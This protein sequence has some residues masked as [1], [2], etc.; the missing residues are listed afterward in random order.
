MRR[1]LTLSACEIARELA[2]KPRPALRAAPDHDGVGAGSEQRDV[3]IVEWLNVAIDDDRDRDRLLDGAHRR[4]VG[5]AVVELAAGT[6]VHGDK[7][8]AR[9]FGAARQIGRVERGVVPAKPHFQR[10]RNLDRRHDC[11]DQGERMVEIAHQRRTG[12]A[13]GDVFG[14]AAHVDVDDLGAARLGDARAFGHPLRLAARDLHD[15]VSDAVPFGAKARIALALR[16]R[17]AGHHL[18]D[19]EAGA[20]HRGQR[21]GTARR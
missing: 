11:L 3:G 2:G 12:L 6:A 14:R 17:R 19:D 16:E 13:V 4:P 18:G 15:V 5:M 8:D 7:R 9:L 1:R 10:H 20:Q 21:A